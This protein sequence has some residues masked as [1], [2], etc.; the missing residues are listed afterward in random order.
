MATDAFH[1]TI[2]KK[3]GIRSIATFDKDFERVDF[4]KV[5]IPQS[6][7]PESSEELRMRIHKL[8]AHNP[9]TLS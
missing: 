9:T 7:E 4:I 3:S 5:L 6:K 8:F 2:M 1:V